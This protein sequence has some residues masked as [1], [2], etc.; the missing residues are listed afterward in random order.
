LIPITLKGLAKFM[1][2]SPAKQRKILRDFK[3]PQEE[4]IPQALYYREA[5]DFI[6]AYY[7]N[8]HPK[9]WLGDKARQLRELAAA[10]GGQTKAR[11]NHNAR[12]LEAYANHFSHRKF[13]VL[14]D[15]ALPLIASGVRVKV[16]P[17][18]HVREGSTERIIKLEFT[19]DEPVPQVIKIVSQAMYEAAL[20]N[21]HPLLSGGVLYMDVTR[22]TVHKGA[23]A[24]SRIKA[25]IEAACQNIA[26]LWPLI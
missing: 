23:R 26:A 3:Y 22:G 15:L 18:L 17:D 9:A 20:K 6:C 16:T 1:V 7:R 10:S 21:N 19:R 24:G 5:R 12:S 25:E 14:E 13:D 2:A 8:H 4:G 11:L